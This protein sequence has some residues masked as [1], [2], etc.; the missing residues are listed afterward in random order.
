M[1]DVEHLYKKP[2]KR[3]PLTLEELDKIVIP[4]SDEVNEVNL[5]NAEEDTDPDDE[6]DN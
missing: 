1:A 2:E 4:P 6:D 5:E 3:K